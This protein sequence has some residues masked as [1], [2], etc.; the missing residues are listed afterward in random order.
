MDVRPSRV[1]RQPGIPGSEPQPAQLHDGQDGRHFRPGLPVPTWIQFFRPEPPA[2]RVSRPIVAQ[3]QPILQEARELPPERERV[4]RRL[5]QRAGRQASVAGLPRP[6][7]GWISTNGWARSRRSAWRARGRGSVHALGHRT[8]NMVV[9]HFRMRVPPQSL[10][11]SLACLKELP[12]RV[13]PAGGYA[14]SSAR[15]A[16][17]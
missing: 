8:P 2:H 10:G 9:D 5:P 4:V 6:P 16:N 17:S 7:R 3:L 13:R 12:A 15:H 11:W 14:P 1:E